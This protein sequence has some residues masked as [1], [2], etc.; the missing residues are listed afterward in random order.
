MATITFS[1][2]PHIVT[3][4]TMWPIK[5][6]FHKIER[7]AKKNQKRKQKKSTENWT[8]LFQ[9]HLKFYYILVLWIPI[10]QKIAK[11]STKFSSLVENGSPSNLLMS[12]KRRPTKINSNK[13]INKKLSSSHLDNTDNFA[14]RILNW[15]TQNVIV[16]KVCVLVHALI[17]AGVFIYIYDIDRLN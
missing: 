8:Q 7:F 1:Y 10:P 16:L 12:Y 11:A 14:L 2:L 6:C 13:W 4:N 3:I 9:I 17:E 5:I 15:H